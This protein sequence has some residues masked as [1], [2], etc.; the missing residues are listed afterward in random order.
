MS[1]RKKYLT[2]TDYD[3]FKKPR[4]I[5]S[6]KSII[7]E[8]RNLTV[9][10]INDPIIGQSYGFGGDDI[11]R[12]Y[13]LGRFKDDT[14]ESAKLPFDVHVM[15]PKNKDLSEVKSLKDLL[16]IGWATVTEKV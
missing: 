2:S 6:P 16:N 10:E 7:I 15:I 5:E 14:V 12:L 11:T 3:E 4:I 1:I 9:V 8:S 13:L